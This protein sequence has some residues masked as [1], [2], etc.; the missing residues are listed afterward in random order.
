MSPKS[1]WRATRVAV[2]VSVASL[3]L[4]ACGGGSSESSDEASGGGTIKWAVV[5]PPDWDPVIQAQHYP[6]YY[7][8]LVYEPLVGVDEKGQPAPGLAESWDFSA[9]GT[10]LTL[11]LREGQEFTD[12]TPVDAEAVKAFFDRALTEE[13][14]ARKVDFESIDTVTADSQWKVTLHLKRPNYPILLRLGPKAGQV[15][16]PAIAPQDLKQNPVG[17]GP[18]KVTEFVEGDHVYLEKNPDYWDADSI[19]VDKVEFYPSPTAGPQSVAAVTSGQYTITLANDPTTRAAAVGVEG[20]RDSPPGN[21]NN[22]FID[23]NVSVAPFNDP[24]V[25]KAVNLAINR[26]EFVARA[27]AGVG[28]PSTQPYQSGDIGYVESF[29]PEFDIDK[30]KQVL[31]AA[32]YQ[33]GDIT[34]AIPSTALYQSKAEVLQSQLKAIGIETTIE[35]LP[36]A[37][38]AKLLATKS[39][40]YPLA[41]S[42]THNFIDPLQTFSQQYDQDGNVNISGKEPA[43]FDALLAKAQNVPLDSPEYA[44]AVEA[45]AKDSLEFQSKIYYATY[46]YSYLQTTKL[47]D[48]P[49][50]PGQISLKGVRFK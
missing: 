42:G 2:I 27:N 36:D 5:I 23:L 44:A 14:S 37:E 16:S 50:L 10:T 38:S 31:E 30:A 29:Q 41:L 25:V 24:E 34:F 6:Q 3:A 22:Y 35:I 28:K 18:F 40:K 20:I 13:D 48:L 12:G 45:L 43:N 26:E 11:N 32:G 47:S 33:S 49:S 1:L 21:D 8:S 9:D 17:A 15:P 46:N 7:S 19:L 39:T 4:T